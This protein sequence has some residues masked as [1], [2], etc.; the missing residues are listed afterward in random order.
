MMTASV[1]NY[2]MHNTAKK[3]QVEEF[4]I[5]GE[6][7]ASVLEVDLVHMEMQM[8]GKQVT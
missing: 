1:D 5:N 8:P 2:E 7:S 4:N 3:T 6:G